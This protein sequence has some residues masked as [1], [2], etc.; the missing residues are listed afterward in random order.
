M[1]VRGSV[2]RSATAAAT[3]KGRGARA[4]SRETF[5]AGA[6]ERAPATSR[7]EV[8]RLVA[9]AARAEQYIRAGNMPEQFQ[10][11]TPK[12]VDPLP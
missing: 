3:R 5:D 12:E 11:G 9:V 2:H 8:S 4:A 10:L 6:K 1:D 7:A